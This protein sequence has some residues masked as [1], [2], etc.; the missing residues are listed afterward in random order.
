MILL[1]DDTVNVNGLNML[2]NHMQIL[3]GKVTM[4]TL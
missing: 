1:I 2:H 3:L 4:F